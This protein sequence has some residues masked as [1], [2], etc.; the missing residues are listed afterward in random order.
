MSLFYKLAYRLGVTPWEEAADHPAAA[1]V[2]AALFDREQE[3]RE[4]PYGRVLDLGCGSGHWAVDLARRGWEVVGVDIVPKAL[5]RARR[6]AR[7]AGVEVELIEGD[8]TALHAA[9]V[10][11]GFDLF[12]D[13]GSIHGLD[14]GQRE[15]VGRE[16]SAAAAPGARA[17]ILAWKPGRRGPLPRG[18]SRTEIEA[19]FP[20]WEVIDDQPFDATGLPRPL[21]GVEPRVYRLRR[22]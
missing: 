6:R 22:G 4:P 13:F 18:A 9:G 17:L 14:A 19:A 12:W 11:S 8:L 15:A 16:V 1:Q 7:N 3:G 21:R 20:D 10:G 2:I 5:E